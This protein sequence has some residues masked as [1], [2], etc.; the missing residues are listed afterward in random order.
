MLQPLQNLVQKL[1]I[2]TACFSWHLFQILRTLVLVTLGKIITRA[3]SFG[4]S[5][6][7]MHSMVV[8]WDTDVLFHGGLLQLGLDVQDLCVLV[9][10]CL[11]LLCVSI[12]QECG[13]QV[14]E[15]LAKQTQ[16]SANEKEEL[17]KQIQSLTNEIQN[18]KS[19]HQNMSNE[20]EKV[21]RVLRRGWRRGSAM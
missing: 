14:R 18:L 6:A 5:V 3:P 16:N 21:R 7:M 11:V 15:T 10:A 13:I 1:K 8:Q 19:S 17:N 20:S 2:N 4:V 12:L 9:F